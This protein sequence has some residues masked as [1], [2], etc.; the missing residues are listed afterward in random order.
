[1]DHTHNVIQQAMEIEAAA[2]DMETSM[3]GY[4]LAGEED[5]LDPYK[6]GLA[7]FDGKLTTLKGTVSDNPEQYARLSEI[8]RVHNEWQATVTESA[9]ALRREIGNAKSMNDMAALVGEARGKVYFDKFR[10]QI[11]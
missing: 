9:I 3:R 1:M 2:V 5:F 4:L 11:S 6:E 7:T 10:G 8:G